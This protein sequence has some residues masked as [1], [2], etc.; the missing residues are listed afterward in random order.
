[1]FGDLRCKVPIPAEFGYDIQARDLTMVPFH[2]DF[3]EAA[4]EYATDSQKMLGMALRLELGST[5]YEPMSESYIAPWYRSF[6]T[7]LPQITPVSPAQYTNWMQAGRAEDI[8]SL[9]WQRTDTKTW[10]P[11]LL[12]WYRSMLV[13]FGLD[14]LNR[15][16]I[17]KDERMMYMASFKRCP[18]NDRYLSFWRDMLR[19]C[20]VSDEDFRQWF[21]L[22]YALETHFEGI[23]VDH[24]LSEEEL[25]RAADLGL[26][27]RDVLTQR[28]LFPQGNDS[29]LKWLTNPR[30]SRFMPRINIYEKY[31]WAKDYVS[32]IMQRV[33]E[34]EAKRGELATPLTPVAK[35]IQ[36]VEGAVHFVRLLAAL[37]KEN[38]CRGYEYGGSGTKRDVL[39]HLLK[40]CYPAPEDTPEHLAACLKETDIKEKRLAEAVMYAPQWASLAEKALG[41][42]GLKR[43]VW[44]FHAHINEQFSA[45]KETEAALYSPITPQQFND[46][47]FDKEWFLQAYKELGEKR[48]QVLYQ[49]AK[50]ITTGSNQHK[51]SQLY[52]DAVLGRLSEAELKAEIVAKRNQERLRCYPLLP[53]P[54]DRTRAALDRYTFLRQF[55]KESKQFGAQRRE[56]EKKACLIA[57][58]NLAITLGFVD[59]NRMIWFLESEQ[60]EQIRPLLVPTQAGDYLLWLEIAADGTVEVAVEKDGR[61][62]KSV[63][64]ALKKSELVMKLQATVKELK[65]QKRRGRESLEKA[66]VESAVFPVQEL[67]NVLRNPVLAP[68]LRALVWTDGMHF[69]FLTDGGPAAAGVSLID[70]RGEIVP[71]QAELRIAHPHDLLTAQEWASF[72]RLLFEEKR[73]QPFKQVFREYYPLT[74]DE[75]QERMISRRYAGHQ[76][77]TQKTA[78]LLKGRGWTVDYE[79]GLQKVY[80]KENLVVRMYA[81]A[82]WF[83]PADI[84]APTLEEVRFF[85]RNTG[86]PVALEDVPPIVFS[87]VMRDLDLVVSVAHV[88]GVDPEASHSTVEMRAAIAAELT[89]LLKLQNVT[90]FETHAKI[91]GALGN[92]SVHLGSG[93]VHAEAKGMIAILP[94]HSQA[95][96]RIFLPFADDDPKTAEILSK[97]ILL[98]EDHKIKDPSILSQL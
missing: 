43:G 37:G 7:K 12:K 32:Q 97:I 68:M 79:E 82:D 58:D 98:A 5:I 41:W 25:F 30:P 96:G 19:R 18:M 75:R 76:V 66:M 81:M 65:E 48:F 69:G 47:A 40:N 2:E 17:A 38:F 60:F 16:Y 35:L 45:E 22:E 80:Y 11:E 86:D 78:A 54:E 23:H 39:S 77:Q 94:V 91:R 15:D 10:M 6:L 83:S 3:L 53:L 52:A 24:G 29:I 49:S 73:Q 92:Y 27:P 9:I 31:S 8:F 64:T 70:V 89:W 90:F 93:I 95:R 26:V 13:I 74:A 36:R 21:E 50:Y 20:A 44:F 57:L 56:S 46:G 14:Q 87:E 88:G 55:Q 59:T 33:V 1:M 61:R 72:M 67:R 63:P 51:R 84:E 85:D 71:A 42:P 4:G 28:L 62:L 34:V